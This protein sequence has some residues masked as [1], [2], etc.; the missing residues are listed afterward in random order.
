[1]VLDDHSPKDLTIKTGFQAHLANILLI[2][3]MLVC[4]LLQYSDDSWK[5][6]LANFVYS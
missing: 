4:T 2:L 1:M 6:N 3:V 5:K